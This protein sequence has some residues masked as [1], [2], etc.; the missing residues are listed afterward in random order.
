M[1]DDSQLV[2]YLERLFGSARPATFVELR[3]RTGAGMRQRFLPVADLGAVARE[4]TALG[5][6]HDLYVGV[7]PRWR[8][9]GRRT[10]VVGDGRTVWVDLDRPDA[11]RVLEGVDPPASVIVASGGRGHVHAYWRLRRAVP[12]R[13]IERANGRLA[14]ALGGDLWAGDAARILRPPG[15]LNLKHDTLV[16]LLHDADQ[17]TSLGELV[18]GLLDPPG[19]KSP[20]PRTARRPRA[21][22]GGLGLTPEVYVQRLTG[23]AVGRSRKVRCPMHEDST[24]SLHVYPDTERGWFCFGCG[25]GGTV[26]DLAAGIWGR[27]TSGRAY[28][29]LRADLDAVLLR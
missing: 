5:A 22:D 6:T 29:A 11:L 17:A 23:Q 20:T 1:G 14:W 2:R 4:I 12:P 18:G 26:I 19:W 28:G 7:L 8:P 15:T 16:E 13:V 21:V 24:P 10:D 3:W 25:R 9:G 27:E